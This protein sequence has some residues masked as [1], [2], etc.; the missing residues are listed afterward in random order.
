MIIYNKSGRH[1]KDKSVL[2]PKYA[3]CKIPEQATNKQNSA[4]VE[5]ERSRKKDWI[6][7]TS[8]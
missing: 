4:T 1:G 6:F 7:Q 2:H 5:Q 3:S 8:P